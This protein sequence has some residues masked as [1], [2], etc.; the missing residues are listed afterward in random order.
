MKSRYLFALAPF[1]LHCALQAQATHAL[2]NAGL[3][4][5]P[6]VL[7]MAVGDSIHLT[8]SAPHTCTQ[9]SEATWNVN[10]NTSNG[11]FN[12]PSGQVTF[13]LDTPGTYYYV[14][15]VHA[16]MGMKGKIIVQSG[17]GIPEAAP[18]AAFQL[19]PNP[20]NSRVRI[21]GLGAGQQ[22]Q[23]LNAAGA[24]VPVARL[25]TPD[26]LDISGL[27]TGPY[28]VVVRDAHGSLIGTRHLVV[29]R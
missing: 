19:L 18:E 17:T 1:F 16:G 23:V 10:G 22:V 11:G 8:L 9:V 29:A 14:C 26:I 3:S 6:A 7:T 27:G 15:M 24:L 21:E 5:S 12:H 13:A 2:T 4:F 28:S 20:A 25:A